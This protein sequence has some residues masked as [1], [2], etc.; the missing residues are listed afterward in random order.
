MVGHTVFF[1]RQYI[2]KNWPK[3]LDVRQVSQRL[4]DYM[5]ELVHLFNEEITHDVRK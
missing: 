1:A 3:T 2:V 4:R 5:V